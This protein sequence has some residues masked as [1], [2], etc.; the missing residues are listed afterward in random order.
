MVG[1]NDVSATVYIKAM[2]AGNNAAY[3]AVKVNY[4][5][6]NPPKVQQL[7]PIQA[8]VFEDR[9]QNTEAT[10]EFRLFFSDPEGDKIDTFKINGKN[11]VKAYPIGDRTD[12]KG[13]R[14]VINKSLISS[15]DNG[16]HTLYMTIQDE[17]G[18]RTRQSTSI[19]IPI[20][21]KYVKAK[22][23]EVNDG[24]GVDVS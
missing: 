8:T 2:T 13:M 9:I 24:P 10:K 5:V 19:K 3:K 20:D 21:I 1:Q 17:F 22:R 15:T 4:R 23:E 7:R 6:N 16:S 12:M 11:W 18:D 14:F